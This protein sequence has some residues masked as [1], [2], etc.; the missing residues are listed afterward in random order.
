M[1]PRDE[2]AYCSLQDRNIFFGE[3]VQCPHC[4]QVAKTIDHLAT[5]CDRMLGHDYTRRHNEVV[6]CIHLNLCNKY[7]L[8]SSKKLR[9]H[10]VQEVVANENVEI[11]VDTRI[12]TDIKIQHDRPDIFVMD[13]KKKE[14]TLI[15][16]GITNLD[17]L[18]RV[19][20]EKTRKYDLVAN[21]LGLSY[22]CR[23]KIIPYVMTWDGVVTKYHK[24]H[25]NE[26]GLQPKVEAYIQSVVLKKTLESVSFERRR[27]I[28]E[29]D[30]HE[31]IAV[32]MNRIGVPQME[33]KQLFKNKRELLINPLNK[34]YIHEIGYFT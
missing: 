26:I 28:E 30:A 10:S 5:K 25:S 23:V 9:S 7:G 8:K 1:K 2:G 19:E 31:R 3:K 14:I 33:I 15:E 29:E 27:G 12:K 4:R 34:F 24:K 17:L 20:N 13:K 18:T 11:R 32:L 21:E 22:K 16:I 6:K